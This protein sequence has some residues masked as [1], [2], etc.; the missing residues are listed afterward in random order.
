MTTV[1]TMKT[2]V[3]NKH[4]LSCDSSAIIPLC[5]HSLMLAKYV[6]T[7]LVCMPAELNKEIKDLQIYDQIVI[8]N[9]NMVISRCCSAEDGTEEL[10]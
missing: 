7:K 3:E 9:T 4:L 2:S 5:S 10:F 8:V 1:M 6:K